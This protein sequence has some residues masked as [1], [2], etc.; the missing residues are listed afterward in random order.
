[1]LRNKL[2][3]PSVFLDTDVLISSILSTQGAAHYVI[4]KLNVK[5]HITQYSLVEIEEVSKRLAISPKKLL[6]TIENDFKTKTLNETYQKCEELYSNYVA[7]VNDSHI[8]AGAVVSD[9]QY[10]LTYNK[11][12][13]R[14]SELL[15]DFNIIIMTPGEFMQFMRMKYNI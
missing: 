12:H 10:L 7:D 14:S 5:K 6:D 13:F 9:V 11:K 15:R 3:L 2:F 4:Y 1:M 8:V